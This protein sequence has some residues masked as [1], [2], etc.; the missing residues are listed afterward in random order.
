MSRLA[1]GAAVV[2]ERHTSVFNFLNTTRDKRAE[3]ERK[4][5]TTV[6]DGQGAKEDEYDD[7]YYYDDEAEDEMS[8]DYDMDLPRGK[9]AS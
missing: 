5:A 6:Q 1:S 7:E 3:E 8:G 4:G 9:A 2:R